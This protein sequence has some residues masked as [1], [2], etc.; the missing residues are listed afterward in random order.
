MK[1][2][3]KAR[4]AVIGGLA[5]I[6]LSGCVATSS[7][8]SSAAPKPSSTSASAKQKE[9]AADQFVQALEVIDPETIV[10]A[11]IGKTYKLGKKFVMHD[12]TIV[13]PSKGDC[14][15]DESLAFAKK[16]LVG[17]DWDFKPDSVTNGIYVDSRGV[18]YGWL[19][20]TAGPYGEVM[21]T[22]G[23]AVN[24]TN[25]GTDIWAPYQTDA[26]ATNTGLWA[27]CPGFGS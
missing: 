8:S 25:D 2:A 1:I 27:T 5:V 9:P 26:K 12:N 18:H 4:A 15:Y 17:Q 21:I 11:P 14:G 24:A 10:V 19:S 13:T 23:M 20:S 22:A 16:T 7:P 3:Q 6:L